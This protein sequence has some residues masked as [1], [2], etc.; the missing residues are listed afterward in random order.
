MRLLYLCSLSLVLFLAINVARADPRHAAPNRPAVPNSPAA[1][2]GYLGMVADD[3]PKGGGVYVV[4]VEPG[5]PSAAVG[6]QAGDFIRVANGVKIEQVQQLVDVVGRLP[7]G[8]RLT[9]TLERH[10]NI[11]NKTIFM[12]RRADFAPTAPQAPP[13]P[14]N[15][16]FAAPPHAEGSTA[17]EPPPLLGVRLGAP[18]RFGQP[19]ALVEQVYPG[20]AA[21]RA[22]VPAGAMIVALAD[23][24]VRTAD[25]LLRI[26]GT[27]HVGQRVPLTYQLPGR[28]PART[29]VFLT[30]AQPPPGARRGRGPQALLDLEHGLESLIPSRRNG[31]ELKHL[32][33]R[34]DAM[35]RQIRLLERRIGEL[36][37]HSLP[38]L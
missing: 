23:L 7:V 32:N 22:G 14:A 30:D 8:A 2:S 33:E 35:D 16:R 18:R 34:I 9:L 28:Q 10:E 31:E 4:S 36:E 3:S 12:G 5:G 20:M 17:D 6:V 38:K 13:P 25:E 27:L 11:L 26:M 24:P 1:A 29:T 37:R 19:G 15:P 21:D